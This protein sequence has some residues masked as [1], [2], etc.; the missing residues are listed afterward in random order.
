M[1]KYLKYGLIFGGTAIGA[2]VVVRVVKSIQ[3]KRNGGG[4]GD[5]NTGSS[6]SSSTQ[7]SSTPSK[8]DKIYALAAKNKSVKADIEAI[9][10]LQ[11]ER[12]KAEKRGNSLVVDGWFGQK[13]Y[14]ALN[15]APF[16]INSAILDVVVD[17][18]T[19]TNIKALLNQVKSLIPSGIITD[20][21]FK[22]K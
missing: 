4:N 15:I 3:N 9:Q 19:A 20:D 17:K 14:N 6:N 16:A 22:G 18:P 8:F 13:T 5:D 2:F 12:V 7:G 11:N 21:F 1:N 10:T